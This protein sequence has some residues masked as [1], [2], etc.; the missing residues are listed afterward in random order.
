[1][2]VRSS[3]K[4]GLAKLAGNSVAAGATLLIYHRVGGG[5]GDE[6]DLPVSSLA[7]QIE[8]LASK[9]DVL[10]LD[11]ALDRLDAGD[12]RPS[13]V[14]TFDD[15]F[16]DVH[17]RAFP[18]LR[19]RRLPFT[20]YLAAGLVG[21]QMRWEGST[22][23]SQGAPALSW[24]QVIELHASGLCTLGNHT[25]DHAGPESV[26]GGQL[27]RCSDEVEARVGERPRHFAWT[28]GVPVPLLLPFV[29]QR[30]RSAATG[31]LGRNLPTD[32]RHALR[33]VPV[34]ASDPVPFFEAKLTGNL[35][36]ERAYAAIV[37]GGKVARRVVRRG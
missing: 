27:E 3:L 16:A 30:F 34:R 26:D 11:R 13:V 2:T 5:S 32:D 15:G 36:P 22:A 29:R 1:V 10:S 19:E 37:R 7:D 14:L 21:G 28:W 9:H 20:V 8:V 35:G 23:S 31:T 6:L 17:E 24:D 25:W 12:D 4:G 33:R 18:L